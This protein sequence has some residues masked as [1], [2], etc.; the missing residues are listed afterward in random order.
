MVTVGQLLHTCSSGWWFNDCAL[1]VQVESLLHIKRYDDG[2]AQKTTERVIPV[3]PTA[4]VEEVTR[5]VA[6]TGLGVPAAAPAVSRGAV[7]MAR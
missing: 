1:V 3:D 4:A 7:M 6:D 2:G 5:S